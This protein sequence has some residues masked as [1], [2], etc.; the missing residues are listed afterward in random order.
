M[1]TPYIG[2]GS[3]YFSTI[4]GKRF[5][6]DPGDHASR[7]DARERAEQHDA[8]R[9]DAIEKK[10]QRPLTEAEYYAGS[11][12]HSDSR[13]LLTREREAKFSPVRK[14]AGRY[15]KM[16]ADIQR[17]IQERDVAR[18]DT[19]ERQLWDIE[20]LEQ[21]DAEQLAEVAAKESHLSNPRTKAALAELNGLLDSMRWDDS[22]DAGEVQRVKNTLAQWSDHL[23]DSDVAETMLREVLDHEDQRTQAIE[24]QKREAIA[25]IEATLLG[26]KQ[27]RRVRVDRSATLREQ[28][29]ALYTG[30]LD[31]DFS[32]AE[33]ERVYEAIQGFDGEG[34]SAP[35][36]RL[37]DT[38]AAE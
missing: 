28:A 14:P 13:D 12:I 35:L 25:A 36:E 9:V 21:Q 6:F 38:F 30:M 27:P 17:K 16:K 5:E 19:L 24:S 1:R 20:R 8:H 22:R 26:D 7:Q 23:A 33:S 11:V 2:T 32:F 31:G 10:L 4:D 15:D 34:N 3:N 37:L 18:M 29:H